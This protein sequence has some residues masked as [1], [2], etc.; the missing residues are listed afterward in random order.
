MKHMLSVAGRFFDQIQVGRYFSLQLKEYLEEAGCVDVGQEI[1]SIK[2]G[3]KCPDESMG[4]KAIEATIG[5]VEAMI[6][7]AKRKCLL[8]FLFLPVFLQR[9]D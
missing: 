3:S 5:S 1:V 8:R 6:R 4:K 2:E 7:G 9:G